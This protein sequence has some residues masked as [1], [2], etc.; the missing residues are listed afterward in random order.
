MPTNRHSARF[1][2]LLAALIVTTA[3]PTWAADDPNAST[4]RESE[5]LAV[6]RSDTPAA[7]KAIAC[8]LLAIHGSNEAVPDLA[9]LL[10]DPQLSS[11]ARIALEA[12]PGEVAD[13]ALR[14][15]T[16]SLEG[17][18]LIG[19]LNSIG[20]R[21]D[22]KAVESLTAYLQDD[23]AQVASAAA[24]ALGRIG[25]VAATESLRQRLAIGSEE[26]RSAVA[27]GCVLCAERLLAD[28]KSAEAVELY[29]EVRGAD[30]PKQRILEATRGAILARNDEGIP[31]LLEQFRSPDKKLFQLALITAREFPGGEVDKALAEEMTRAKPR[32]AALMI[33][34]MA[35]REETVVLPAVLQAAGHGPKRVRLAAINALGRVGDASCLSDLLEIALDAKPELTLAAKATLA[36]LPGEEVNT[37]IVAR[38]ADAKGSVYPLLIALVGQRR[39]DAVPK[40][41][42]A[43]DHSDEEVRRAAL[44]AL[45]ETITSEGLSVLIAQVVSPKHREDVPVAERALKAASVRMP[46]REACAAEL[47]AALEQ[48][49]SVTTK[50][51]LLNILGEVGG[52]EALATVGAAAKS[53]E[54]QLQDVSSRLLGKWMTADAAPVLLDL[55]KTAP[56]VKYHVRAI[57]GYIR[58]ARQFVL[59]QEQ[60]AEM[61]QKALEAA[62]RANERK[63]VLQVLK[64]YPN[65]EMFKLA[66][67][68]T[69]D[70]EMKEEATQAVLFIAEKLGGR[71]EEI[72]AILS[73]AGFEKVKLEIVKA[74]YGAGSTQKDVTGVL[75]KQAGDSP[76]ILLASTSYN[77]SFGGDPAPGTKKKLHIEYRINGKAGEASF[78]ENALIVLPLPK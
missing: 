33:Q 42:E 51:T 62:R 69:H 29:D 31:L 7:D 1:V 15:A 55:A 23:D 32:R 6:L 67:K 2:A 45:G 39:I 73:D 41:L 76:L 47:S 58:I 70:P 28:G 30:V 26:V 65:G 19:M 43:L 36:E 4:G 48:T 40:L 74:E 56:E 37:Q 8:K 64:R 21:R 54:P 53:G 5:L 49:S 34:A 35:D 3:A 77:T 14:K 63:L 12:I 59:P 27:E 78:A 68:S 75:R 10:P 72:K 66:V 13:E 52:T 61:C 11:W 38:L 57:R 50:G 24:V 71:A 44:T 9:K 25:D 60:R 17:R 46:D 20:V 18:L 16:E 22:A